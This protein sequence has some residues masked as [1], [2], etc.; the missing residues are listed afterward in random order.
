M[1][2]Y[3]L[4]GLRNIW[5]ANGFIRKQTPEGEAIS[6]VD[7]DGLDRAIAHKL[8]CD[9]KRLSG[10]E[11]RFLRK[12]LDMSQKGISELMGIRPLQIHRWESKGPTLM[13]DHFIRALY[14]A[15]SRQ[16]PSVVQVIERINEKDQRQAKFTF[17]HNK[18]W[19]PT[20]A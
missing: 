16:F 9:K 1:Y 13:A 7:G 5:L 3:T 4:C 12:Q 6:I 20:A 19:R 17:N 18:E 14:V 15:N 2:H 8:V 10:A 11:F